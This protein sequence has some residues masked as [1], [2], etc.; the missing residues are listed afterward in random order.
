MR[1]RT[2]TEHPTQTAGKI[3]WQAMKT[4][5]DADVCLVSTNNIPFPQATNRANGPRSPKEAES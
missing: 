3:G 1:W 4:P 5:I 2:G